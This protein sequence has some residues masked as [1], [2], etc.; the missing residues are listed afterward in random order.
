MQLGRGVHCLRVRAGQQL[1]L[2]TLLDIPRAPSTGFVYTYLHFKVM[3]F[4]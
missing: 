1:I 2:L 3:E 4:R